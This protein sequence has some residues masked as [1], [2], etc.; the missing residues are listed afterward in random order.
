MSVP[1]LTPAAILL[2]LDAPCPVCHDTTRI[3]KFCPHCH[4]TGRLVS[5]EVRDGV[6]GALADARRMDYCEKE[7]VITYP[8]QRLPGKT[9]RETIDEKMAQS[10]AKEPA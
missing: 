6:E 5:K 1:G 9:L 7:M 10:A 8:S 3:Y 4:G 2:A